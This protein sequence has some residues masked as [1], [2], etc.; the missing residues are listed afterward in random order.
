MAA[1]TPTSF[2]LPSKHQAWSSVC[3]HSYC[4]EAFQS[5]Q[6]ETTY[7]HSV[8]SWQLSHSTQQAARNYAWKLHLYYREVLICWHHA[9]Q[10]VNIHTCEYSFMVLTVVVKR[11]NVCYTAN[12]SSCVHNIHLHTKERKYKNAWR[13][14]C[15]G[16]R[17]QFYMAMFW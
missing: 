7:M 6:A 17:I 12:F 10:T 13:S 1:P 14:T 4:D 8:R 9:V 15:M 5:L 3:Y 11:E 2:R 16:P